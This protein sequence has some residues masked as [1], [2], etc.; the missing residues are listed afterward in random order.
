M[1]TDDDP[2]LVYTYKLSNYLYLYTSTLTVWAWSTANTELEM[3]SKKV[4]LITGA[5]QG[6]GLATTKLLLRNGARV[7]STLITEKATGTVIIKFL[8][9]TSSTSHSQS[10]AGEHVGYQ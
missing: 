3:L 4:A 2:D 8:N 1:D 7:R 5:A 10:P 6:I 9:Y